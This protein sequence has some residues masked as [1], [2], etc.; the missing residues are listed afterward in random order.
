MSIRCFSNFSSD[1]HQHPLHHPLLFP[2]QG[3]TNN[4]KYIIKMRSSTLL[5]LLPLA[6][7]A[8]SSIK[9][10]RDTPA[11]LI[12][13]RGTSLVDGKYI[14]K[15]KKDVVTASINSA[16]SSIKADADYTYADHF[17]GFA[18]SLTEE[19]LT[20]LRDDPTV[21]YVEQDAIITISAT[22]SNA[23][24]G[25]ARISSQSPGG[26]TYTYDD[27]AG[28]GTCAYIVDTGIDT[29]HSV[30]EFTLLLSQRSVMC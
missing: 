19:E 8:P 15:F 24:W 9:A 13:P 4:P 7:A 10:K 28:T 2:N 20:T 23:P 14:V 26:T 17:N 1:P 21:E 6:M 25:L 30:S 18:A 29:T 3:P 22:Q 12:I 11:P 27:T 5:A 16:I